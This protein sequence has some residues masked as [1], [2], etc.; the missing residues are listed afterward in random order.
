MVYIDCDWEPS[1]DCGYCLQSSRCD[2]LKEENDLRMAAFNAA[3]DNFPF[4]G[5]E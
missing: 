5:G 4:L 3:A 2:K 1:K